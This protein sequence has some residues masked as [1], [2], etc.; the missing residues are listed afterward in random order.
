MILVTCFFT[1]LSSNIPSSD[2]HLRAIYLTERTVYELAEKI[3]EKYIVK[4][5]SISRIL[6]INRSGLEVLV[7]DYFVRETAEGQAMGVEIDPIPCH[8]MITSDA[9]YGIRLR[10]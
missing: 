2:R 7:D 10:Y 9:V 6:Y 5:T 4:S 1:L 3:S 8:G